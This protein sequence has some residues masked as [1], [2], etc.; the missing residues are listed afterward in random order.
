MLTG[1]FRRQ[2]IVTYDGTYSLETGKKHIDIFIKE[3]NEIKSLHN[4][5]AFNTAQNIPV[6]R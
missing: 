2:T 5:K 1:L 4:D 3:Q 6:R